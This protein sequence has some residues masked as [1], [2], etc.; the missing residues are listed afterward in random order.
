MCNKEECCEKVKKVV[1]E[2]PC[3][4]VGAAASVGVGCGFLAGLILSKLLK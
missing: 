4:V 2:H 1:K 3:I